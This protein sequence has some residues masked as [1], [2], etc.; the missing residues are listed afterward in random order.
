MRTRPSGGSSAALRDDRYDLVWFWKQNDSGLYG[1]RADQLVRAL[2]ASPRVRRIVHFDRAVAPAELLR[3]VTF[4]RHPLRRHGNLVLARALGRLAPWPLGRKVTRHVFVYGD[5]A[6][7][8]ARR[9]LPRR[10]DYERFVR[11]VLRRSGVGG[12][13]TVFWAYPR[14]F[15]FPGLVRRLAPPLVVADCVDDQRLWPGATPRDVERTEENYRA[16]LGAADL[17]LANCAALR[18]ALAPLGAEAVVLESGADP[19]RPAP[20]C[21]RDLARLARPRIGYVGNLSERLD[22]AL[23][24]AVAERRPEWSLVLIGSAHAGGAIDALRG[25]ANVHRLGVRT[26]PRVR[27]YVAHLDVALLPHLD[28]PLT[29]SMAP[30]KLATYCSESVPVVATRVANL[31]PFEPLIDVADDEPAFVA[32]IER[33][34]AAPRDPARERLR[35]ELLAAHAWER[36]AE[37]AIALLDAAWARRHALTA[38]A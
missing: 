9:L 33:A 36:R 12:A 19:P 5:D 2:A 27:D 10:R 20:P 22:V 7:P 13:R 1:R 31:G 8:L 18:D 30:I 29:R 15:A 16:V 38:S 32:A 23:L 11:R 24:R 25:L 35:A 26:Y 4:G 3:G 17:V 6:G 28:T 14:N 34:L 37:Q 21:P